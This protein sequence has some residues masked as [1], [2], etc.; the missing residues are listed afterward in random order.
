MR[1]R[2]T[3]LFE[4]RRHITSENPFDEKEAPQTRA[5]EL[6]SRDSLRCMYSAEV[7]RKRDLKNNLKVHS[8]RASNAYLSSRC[9]MN[10]SEKLL[11]H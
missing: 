10:D 3:E 11:F 6:E 8:F 9:R 1:K 5:A 4:K 2:C 7:G